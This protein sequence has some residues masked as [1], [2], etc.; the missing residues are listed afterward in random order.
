MGESPALRPSLSGKSAM[1]TCPTVRNDTEAFFQEDLDSR[2]R[3]RFIC[4]V[5]QNII[6][7]TSLNLARM[8]SNALERS[9]ARSTC[10]VPAAVMASLL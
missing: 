4:A 7:V 1:F 10:S 3:K 9:R 5:C 2:S 6:L 8:R